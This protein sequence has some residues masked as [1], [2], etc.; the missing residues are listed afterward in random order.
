M[1]VLPLASSRSRD[2]S[3]VSPPVPCEGEGDAIVEQPTAQIDG[4]LSAAPANGNNK[5]THKQRV[6]V[7]G[8]VRALKD[9]YKFK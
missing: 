1:E 6:A 7:L 5:L 8:H 9:A 3:F 4:H 2:N